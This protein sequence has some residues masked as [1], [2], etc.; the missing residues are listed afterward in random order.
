MTRI[1]ETKVAASAAAGGVGGALASFLLWVLG[2][3]VW[4]APSAA[5]SAD[6]ATAAVPA[7]VAGLLLTLLPAGLAL[8]GGYL[9]PH[10]H[11]PDLVVTPPVDQVPVTTFAAPQV[12]PEQV[13]GVTIAWP[14][15]SPPVAFTYPV[16]DPVPVAPVPAPVFEQSTPEPIPTPAPI[17]AP[18][19]DP[20]IGA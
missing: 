12:I 2:V 15:V 20:S 1:L 4:G 6:V 14:K 3:T 8:L 11:R 18:V 9:A 13:A 16:A 17:A 7:P 5:G 10:T 19:P